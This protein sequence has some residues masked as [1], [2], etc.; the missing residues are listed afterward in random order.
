MG[1]IITSLSL[2]AISFAIIYFLTNQY[3]D[4][5]PE[6]C[7]QWNSPHKMEIITGISILM[8]SLITLLFTGSYQGII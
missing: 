3:V 6:N 7:V 2:V 8:S 4:K 5:A 1:L